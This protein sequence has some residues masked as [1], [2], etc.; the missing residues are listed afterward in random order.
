[1]AVEGGGGE[2]GDAE[3][4]FGYGGAP[5]LDVAL[6]GLVVEEGEGVEDLGAEAV[7]GEEGL[8]VRMMVS[9]GGGCGKG[10]GERGKGKGLLGGEIDE[11][12]E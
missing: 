6:L 8:V 1:M 4:G 11:L 12:T 7:W 10:K 5:G 3:E 9:V 2:A